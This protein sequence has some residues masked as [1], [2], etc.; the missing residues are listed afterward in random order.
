MLDERTLDF[1]S[2]LV[3]SAQWSPARTHE[4]GKGSDVMSIGKHAKIV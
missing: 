4:V 2:G 3:R 1:K